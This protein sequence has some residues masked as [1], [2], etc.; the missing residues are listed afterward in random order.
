MRVAADHLGGRGLEHGGQ[1]EV[2]LFLVE[3][4]HEE[5]QEQYVADLFKR[6]GRVA[7]ADAVHQFE[8]LFDDIVAQGL[9]GLGLIPGTA[10]GAEQGVDDVQKRL[11][12]GMVLHGFLSLAGFGALPVPDGLAASMAL[13]TSS[14]A[15]CSLSLMS[16][17]I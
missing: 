16:G 4:G 7:G 2:A 14:A 6:P 1:V 9:R 15:V 12:G 10:A 8:G 13:G 5:Q 17:G 3:P 11:Q